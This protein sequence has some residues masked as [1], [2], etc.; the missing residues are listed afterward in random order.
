M[1]RGSRLR[2]LFRIPIHI[3]KAPEHRGIAHF[4]HE[5]ERSVARFAHREP[6]VFH[7][8][9]EA[10]KNRIVELLYLPVRTFQLDLRHGGVERR[11]VADGVALVYHALHQLRAGIKVSKRY[12][13]GRADILFLQYIQ[14]FCGVAVFVA[15]IEG[16]VHG[17]QVRILHRYRAELRIIGLLLFRAEPAV[18]VRIIG[19]RRDTRVLLLGYAVQHRRGFR[20]RERIRFGGF[21]R[22]RAFP[23]FGGFLR[24]GAFPRFGGHACRRRGFRR[25]TRGNIRRAGAF[26]SRGHGGIGRGGPRNIRRFAAAGGKYAKRAGGG[27]ERGIKPVVY[28]IASFHGCFTLSAARVRSAYPAANAAFILLY[29]KKVI[30]SLLFNKNRQRGLTRR[31]I[32]DIVST[33]PCGAFVL[34]LSREKGMPFIFSKSVR[35]KGF[36]NGKKQHSDIRSFHIRTADTLCTALSA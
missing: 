17:G 22:R 19:Q 24:R 13:E 16:E 4:L 7:F 3:S 25:G 30:L 12:K 23:R 21:L 8:V 34:R 26:R 9:A 32:R 20:D 28:M 2:L 29:H 33:A 10:G 27:A 14:Y 35:R 18:P 36:Y 6:E 31:I 15:L 1:A 5:R 11:M